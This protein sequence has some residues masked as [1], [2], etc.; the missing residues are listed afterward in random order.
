MMQDVWN[1]S[2]DAQCPG[3][4]QPR[5]HV[6]RYPRVFCGECADAATDSRGRGL[7]TFNT[8]PLGCGFGFSW[9]DEPTTYTAAG[10]IGLIKGHVAYF[11]E[12]RFGGTV[13][14]HEDGVSEQ[15]HRYYDVDLTRLDTH[16]P[17]L[18]VVDIEENFRENARRAKENLAKRS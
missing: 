9:R 1:N 18:T 5:S 16:Q 17:T 8:E 2:N 4:G 15:D 10:M 12:G 13:A 6:P 11:S 14:Q 3:C 7:K